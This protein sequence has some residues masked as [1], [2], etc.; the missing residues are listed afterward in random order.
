LARLSAVEADMT[1]T[2]SSERT[3][4]TQPTEEA[5][6]VAAARGG[7]RDAFAALCE[8]YRHQ[9]HVH[10]YRMLGSVDDA[11]DLVQDTFLKAWQA[12]T[13]FE[14]RS[15]FRTWLYRIATNAS[16]DALARRP[17]RVMPPDV[18]PAEQV[19]NTDFPPPLDLPWLQ[20]YPD[21]LL[22]IPAPAHDEP[23]VLIEARETIEL[24]YL[25]AIQHL[26]ARQRAV[27]ILRDAMSWSA[28]ETAELLGISEAAANS[29]LQRARATMR[30]KLPERRSEWSRASEITDAERELLRRYIAAGEAADATA[31][32]ALLADDVRQTM[33]PLPMWWDGKE[34]VGA[35]N[36]YFLEDRIDGDL[37]AVPTAANRQPAA[38][39]YIRERGEPDFKLIAVDVLTMRDGLITEIDTFDP[40]RCPG[41]ELP[42]VLGA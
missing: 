41:F 16:L 25:A 28:R 34:L 38:A 8:R 10:C 24:A 2:I 33:P 37:R 17:K 39:F 4:T 36:R 5:S 18:R 1:M 42:E 32:T 6:A 9:L 35:V 23:S 26:P 30:T 19:L 7:D 15:L 13:S 14:G 31:F 11:D 40:K 20:P 12:R 29:L 27:L 3:R 22:E 21:R